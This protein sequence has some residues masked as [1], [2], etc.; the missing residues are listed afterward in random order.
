[1]KILELNN[2]SY[3][4][5]VFQCTVKDINQIHTGDIKI[6]NEN[7][8]N[9]VVFKFTKHEHNKIIFTNENFNLTLIFENENYN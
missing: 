1:M 2:F 7:T 9:T 6:T 5:K 4:N 8:K 3:K